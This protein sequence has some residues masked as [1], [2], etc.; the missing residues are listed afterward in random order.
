MDVTLEKTKDL[1]GFVVVKI[2][3]ADYA[4]RVK[5]EL[6]EIGKNRQIPGFRKGHI[7]LAQLRKRFGTEVKAHVLNEV[8]ADACLK[9]VKDNNLDI[10]GQPIPAT[11]EAIDLSLIHI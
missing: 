7:D 4:D 3:E 10:L 9:Y 5:N 1:E 2:Q 8:A 11:D 6:K